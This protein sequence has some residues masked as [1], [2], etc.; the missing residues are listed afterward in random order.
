MIWKKKQPLYSFALFPAVIVFEDSV[1][2]PHDN[3]L[4]DLIKCD[5]LLVKKIFQPLYFTYQ[6]QL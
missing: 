3:T 2:D 1:I 4:E 6:E 5:F